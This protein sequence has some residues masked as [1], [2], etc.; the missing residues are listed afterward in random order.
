MSLGPSLPCS[1]WTISMGTL[2]AQGHEQQCRHV[3]K[4][5]LTGIWEGSG[6]DSWEVMWLL[7]RRAPSLVGLH[8]ANNC[9]STWGGPGRWMES[10]ASMATPSR[11][12]S[13]LPQGM[14]SLPGGHL[15]HLYSI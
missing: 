13:D 10:P 4:S 8:G 9:G 3:P 7:D 2:R 5:S 15:C 6:G 11:P 12:V 14:W 1:S